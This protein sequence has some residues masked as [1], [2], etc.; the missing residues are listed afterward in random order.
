V[1]RVLTFT[2]FGEILPEVR[3]LIPAH[4]TV[5]QWTLAQ[6]CRHLADTI[7]GSMDGFDLR[8]HRFKRF[9]LSKR[10]LRYTYRY[11]IPPG[12]TVDPKLTPPPNVKLDAS[13]AALEQALE[14][15]RSYRGRLRAHPLFG[16]LSRE[17]WD[18]LHCF[19]AAHHL[20][21][22]ISTDE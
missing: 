22:V 2:D 15:Y 17:K 16:D 12:Y 18:E 9:F 20:S 3:R 7:N 21:F 19:H 14:R 11:G 10:L 6:I 5:R 13:L 4:R 8:R 1:R